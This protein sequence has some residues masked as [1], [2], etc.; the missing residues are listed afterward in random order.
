[1]KKAELIKIIQ[2]S[3][4]EQEISTL[5]E[6]EVSGLGMG[7]VAAGPQTG[8]TAGPSRSFDPK[9]AE[10]FAAKFN[11]DLDKIAALQND[12]RFMSNNASRAA[13][14]EFNDYAMTNM[15]ANWKSKWTAALAKANAAAKKEMAG[16]SPGLVKRVAGKVTDK[17][18]QMFGG[19]KLAEGTIK[20]IDTLVASVILQ[21]KKVR[22][23]NEAAAARLLEGMEFAWFEKHGLGQKP[24][25]KND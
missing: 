20:E 18:Q 17:V 16:A 15:P 25:Q 1:M 8:T 19:K 2:E 11:F 21:E 14:A 6:A 13:W 12:E 4:K 23:E 10:A 22:F 24:K 5:F 7:G 3:L 9:R